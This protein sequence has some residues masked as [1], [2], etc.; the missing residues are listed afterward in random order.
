M[1]AELHRCPGLTAELAADP[2]AAD[3][4]DALPF[5]QRLLRVN[6]NLVPLLGVPRWRELR[7]RGGAG[8]A[9]GRWSACICRRATG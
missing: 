2:P 7:V 3:L 5:G 6:L 8:P 1:L 4:P 9:R